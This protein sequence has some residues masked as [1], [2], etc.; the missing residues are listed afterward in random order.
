[1]KIKAQPKRCAH[2]KIKCWSKALYANIKMSC[3]L[4]DMKA[5]GKTMI[6]RDRG[7]PFCQKR[8][9]SAQVEF[10]SMTGG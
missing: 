8:M 3:V 7:L 9:R 5:K 4:K 2:M 6:R 10:R 1:M